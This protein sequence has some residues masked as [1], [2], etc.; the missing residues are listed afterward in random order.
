MPRRTSASTARS[1]SRWCASTSRDPQ[2]RERFWREARAAASVSHPNVCQL[3][4]VGEADGELFIAM[5]LLEGESLAERL[6]RGPIPL[7]ESVDITLAMLSALEAIHARGLVHRD[8]KPSNIFLTAHGVKLLDFGLAR[9]VQEAGDQTEASI[10]MAGMVMGTPH[11][12]SP[13]QITGEP[14]DARSDLFAVGAIL[15][16]LLVGNSAFPG[17]T[18]PQVFH[19]IMYEPLPSL[20]GSPGACGRRSGHPPRDR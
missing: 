8:L 15:F 2:S 9:A 1:P 12:M 4:E 3:Y 13:E 14:L 20:G 10:T 6:A 11:Y 19:A 5:E 18:T 17:K 7:A 16:E